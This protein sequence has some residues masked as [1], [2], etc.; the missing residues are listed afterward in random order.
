MDISN[1]TRPYNN[2][3][4]KSL[5]KKGVP[6]FRLV[7]RGSI[8][9]AGLGYKQKRF[10]Y[11]DINSHVAT[12]LC[13]N[14]NHTKYLLEQC[15]FPV[16]FGEKIYNKEDLSQAFKKLQK[17][18]VIKPLSEM[19]GK[20]I[21]TNI[22]SLEEAEKAFD[23]AIQYTGD[24]VIAEEHILGDDNRILFIGGKFIAGL[25]RTPPFVIGNGKDTISSLIEKENTNR[26]KNQKKVKPI[27]IDETVDNFLKKQ[28]FSINSVLP[29]DKKLFVRMTGNICSGGISEN[30]TSSVHPSI[31]NIGESIVSLLGLEIAGIDIL[32]TDISKP[33]EETGGKIS[34][35]N[36]NPDIVMHTDPYLGEPI[37]TSGI[38]IDYLFPKLQDAWIEIKRN[39]NQIN[40]ASELNKY[41]RTIPK[42]ISYFEKTHPQKITTLENPDKPLLNYL[43]SNQTVAVEL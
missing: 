33:L 21:T 24:Y 3:I 41:L 5:N 27:L 20:G 11:D 18:I 12:R 36:Q 22:T 39:N 16:P 28:G 13:S 37:D 25:K 6:Y 17:P 40:S 4:G 34:E 32:T 38:F 23:I 42:K 15:G 30:I 2:S 43:L 1:I 26:K 35:V 31:I 7:P 19:W 8:F 9:Q 29:S 14:K 10:I